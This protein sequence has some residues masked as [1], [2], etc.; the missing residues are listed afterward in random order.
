MKGMGRRKWGARNFPASIDGDD[1][2]VPSHLLRGKIL[3]LHPLQID[4]EKNNRTNS[5]NTLTRDTKE[6]VA[7]AAASRLL[8]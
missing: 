5:L 7:L 8:L 1:V 3:F 4:K 2:G 6:T